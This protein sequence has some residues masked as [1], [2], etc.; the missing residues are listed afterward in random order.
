VN[1]AT[2]FSVAGIHNGATGFNVAGILCALSV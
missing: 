1:G 2:G